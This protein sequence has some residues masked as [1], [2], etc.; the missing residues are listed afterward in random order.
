MFSVLNIQST[1]LVTE[2]I[3]ISCN[4]CT[5]DLSDMHALIPWTCSHLTYSGKSPIPM[6]QLLHVLTSYNAALF[7]VWSSEN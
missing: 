1:L 6:I 5:N 4:M 2:V 3:H 7:Y